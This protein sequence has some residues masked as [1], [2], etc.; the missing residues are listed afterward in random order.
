MTRSLNRRELIAALLLSQAL[1][2]GARST[3]RPSRVAVLDWGLTSTV[4]ALGIE[5]VGI[6]EIDLY[7]RWAAEPPVPPGV[8]DIGLR[9]EPNLEVIAALEPDLIITTPFSESVRPL[10]ER[11]APTRS[12]A[13]YTASGEPLEQSRRIMRDIARELGV[14]SRAEAVLAEADAT[15]DAARRALVGRALRPLLLAGFMDARHVRIYGANSLFGD[16]LNRIGV[17]NAWDRPTN[18][19]G[20]S[21]VGVSDLAAYP[22]AQ[23]VAIEPIPADAPVNREGP[24]LWQNLPFVRAGRITTLPT[25]WAFGDVVAA[26]RFARLLSQNLLAHEPARAS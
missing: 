17:P 12:Y 5:P 13:T 21:L 24:G 7:R 26:G 6:A 18:Y 19:W 14:E 22:D 16:V 10:L 4:L 11:I 23:L 15:F 3:G 25:A 9:T 20:F 1:P 2:V 8:Q